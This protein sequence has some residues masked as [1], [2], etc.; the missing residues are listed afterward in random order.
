MPGALRSRAR[1]PRCVRRRLRPPADTR[2]RPRLL[3]A[4]DVR[5][6]RRGD[7]CEGH[8]LWRRSLR[9]L[10][11]GD[12]RAGDARHRL[13]R[14]GR[15]APA[16]ARRRAARSAEHRRLFRL[17][18]RRRPQPRPSVARGAAAARPQGRHGLR[19][20][21]AERAARSGRAASCGVDGHR[22]QQP[23]DGARAG[24]RRLDRA[25][26]RAGRQDLGMNRWRDMYCGAAR[27]DDVGR[28]I[29]VA[30]W[31]A[32]RRDH[33]GLIF[34]D[35]RDHTG[36][37]QLVVNPERAPDAASSAH[38]IRSEF[39]V[40]ARGEVV[41]RAPDAVNANIATGAVEI[42]VDELEVVARSEPLPFQLDDDNVEEPLR[43]RYRY[44]DLRR[45]RMQRNLRLSATV[46][47]AI[48]DS[49]EEQG[50]IDVWTPTM[51][52]GT[53]E[54][55]RDFLVPVRL[56]PGKFFALAQSPQLFKQ[57]FMIGGLDRYYQIATAWR[58]EDLRADRQ[59]E[60]RQLDLE[61]AFPTREEVLE[62]LEQV[63]VASFE[64]L[65]RTPPSRPFP[66]MAYADAML[67]YG[68]DKPDL[69]FGLEIQD[70]TALT[71]DSQFGVFANAE[72]VRYLVAP[73]A[74]SRGEL[75]KLEDFAKEWGAKGLA[76]LVYDESGEVRSPIAKF[77]S[78]G[79]LEA[80]RPSPGS[81]VLFVADSTPMVER[82]L[83]ALRLHLGQELRL[84]DES[85]DEFHWVLD[86]PLFLKDED[87]GR[88]TFVHH[89]FTSPA[90][91][92]ED[93]IESDPG[94]ALSQHYDLI[95]NG[96]EQGSGSIRIHRQ[97]IQERVFRAMGMS[98]EEARAK[99][100]WFV[101]AL[102][103]GAPPHGG[104]ALG[105]ERFLA[106]LA[107]ESTIRE[108]IAFPKTASGSDPL[109]GAPAPTTKE[110]LDELGISVK[111]PKA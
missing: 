23:R 57:T 109:T 25:A 51:T 97:E 20:P 69:R 14:W 85:R 15:A 86:F 76:Y 89:P 2:A 72:T 43:L 27:P 6:Q 54:G 98:D 78:E 83:G 35:L 24:P 61:L 87:T 22:R 90:P 8:D 70:A 107:G 66:R 104:F 41:A 65:G 31:V 100:G 40:H 105:I 13:R 47:R 108:V 10:D 111:T 44:L 58:D 38:A 5:I 55:A 52:L 32:R 102:R 71:R 46:V 94:A 36:V 88:W 59:F 79:E 68:S 96:W 92:H 28:T 19:R 62:V 1:V 17:R 26:R 33:G 99:F 103:M 74:F 11:R 77:L 30:G 106:L 3:H 16:L 80:F 53:P 82:V 73:K 34:I 48:R 21:L 49:M 50:F 29:A 75:Q 12:R 110:R 63:V 67:R 93:L 9:R 64:A 101:D 81:T 4:H 18:A 39:V 91:G 37:V 84:V 56:Q 95:W 42:Q 60:F 45:D 7:R